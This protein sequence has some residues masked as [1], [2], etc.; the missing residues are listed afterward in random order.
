MTQQSAELSRVLRR[1]DTSVP[2]PARVWDYW[3]GGTDNYAADRAVSDE[4][5]KLM[6]DLP[7]IARA[8]RQ[9]IGRVVRFLAGD[10]EIDQFLDIGTGIPTADNIHQV[11][12]RVN[13]CARIVYVD[14]DPIVLVHARA[15]LGCG[16]EC[17][18][19]Y[20]D[21]DLRDP[22][23]ILQ[24]ATDTLDF[25]RPIGLMLM[26]VLEFVTDD[27][28]LHDAVTV[29]V[30][31]LASGSYLGIA[32]SVSSPSMDKA[33]AAWNASGATEILLRTPEQ[34]AE[35]FEGFELLPPGIV[36]LP[37]WHPDASTEYTDREVFQFGGLGRKP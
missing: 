25:A 12:Q 37:Q 28:L 11:A 34:L 35:L 19:D 22:E 7:I 17:G 5:I 33:A 32:H 31:A 15:L 10:K 23:P 8:E 21:A 18:I 2:H 14:N 4:I 13:P 1:I 36:S 3:L 24:A 9:F 16:L 26:G 27:T 29:L 6:P 20:I 30:D